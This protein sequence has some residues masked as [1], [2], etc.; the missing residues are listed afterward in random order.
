[1][2]AQKSILSISQDLPLQEVRA[3]ALHRAGYEVTLTDAANALDTF[4]SHRFDLVLMCHTIV[5]SDRVKLAESIHTGSPRIP[6]LLLYNHFERSAAMVDAAL[7][8]LEAPAA[9]LSVVDLLFAK[10]V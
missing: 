2:E 10:A 8:S 3:D 4:R 5:E 9:L 1:V 6:L 7:I